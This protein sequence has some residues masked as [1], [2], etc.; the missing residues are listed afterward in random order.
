MS[1]PR[2]I[3]LDSNA[4]FRLARSIHPLLAGFFGEPPPYSLFVLRVL[5]EEYFGSPRLRTKF[6]WVN[7]PRYRADRETK[8]YSPAGKSAKEVQTAFTYLERHARQQGLNLAPEDLRALAVGLARGFPVVTDD[9]AMEQ[10]ASIFAI[11][12]WSVI[13]LLRVMVNQERIDVN[14]VDVLLKYLDYENDLPMSKGTLRKL[15][16]EYFGRDCSL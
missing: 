1:A 6:E 3:L 7:E 11:E 10:V 12:V 9:G 13:K 5:D 15:Y 4:Y 2:V 8:R 16:K 14:Q